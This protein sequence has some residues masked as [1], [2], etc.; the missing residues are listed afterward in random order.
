MAKPDLS[1]LCEG[2]LVRP[3]LLDFLQGLWQPALGLAPNPSSFSSGLTQHLCFLWLINGQ[4]WSPPALYFSIWRQAHAHS[5]VNVKVLLWCWGEERQISSVSLHPMVCCQFMRVWWSLPLGSAITQT[6]NVLPLGSQKCSQQFLSADFL[7]AACSSLWTEWWDAV[8]TSHFTFSASPLSSCRR[9]WMHPGQSPIWHR[10]PST[11]WH[12]RAGAAQDGAI[13]TP[14]I[15]YNEQDFGHQSYLRHGGGWVPVTKSLPHSLWFSW[16]T[17]KDLMLCIRTNPKAETS[18]Y[19]SKEKCHFLARSTRYLRKNPTPPEK[20][21]HCSNICSSWNVNH[22]ISSPFR[23]P[24]Q[25][26][27]NFYFVSIRGFQFVRII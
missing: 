6:P 1:S 5:H 9:I 16:N 25:Y 22:V 24:P 18:K 26:W 2:C 17:R 7:L 23:S 3:S 12:R 11:Q 13:I 27:L 15:N 21:Q 10:V 14:T 4:V 19:L 20:Y 8:V